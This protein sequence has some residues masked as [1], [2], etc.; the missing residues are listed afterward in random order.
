M[1]S[2]TFLA[3]L[4][5]SRMTPDDIIQWQCCRSQ[6][7][8]LDA[9]SDGVFATFATRPAAA[10][11]PGGDAAARPAAVP[12]SPAAASAVVAAQRAASAQEEA[13]LLDLARAE[14]EQYRAHQVCQCR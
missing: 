1:V 9:D 7:P 3:A 14:A 12:T 2:V 6:G 5:V 11:A 13:V 8:L 10:A 4:A